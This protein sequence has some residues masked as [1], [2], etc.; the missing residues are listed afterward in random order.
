MFKKMT[1][2]LAMFLV[3]FAA[4]HTSAIADSHGEPPVKELEQKFENLIFQETEDNKL[5]N[6]DSIHKLEEDMNGIM[7]FPLTDYYLERFFIEQNGKLKIKATDGPILL[8]MDKEFTLEKMADDHYRLTQQGKNQLKGAYTLTIDYKYSA[9]R[10]VLAD[11]MDIADSE[12]GG[13]LPD[14]A[15]SMP[16]MMMAGGMLMT[17]GALLI[18]R[19]RQTAN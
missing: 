19:R 1:V 14:T 8:N 18:F 15:T 2:G 16:T 6:Y 12:Y 11:R 7:T 4:L 17:I 3:V 5:K 10:W 13:Q 9:G